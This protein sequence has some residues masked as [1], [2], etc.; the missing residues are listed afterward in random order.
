[1][2]VRLAGLGSHSSDRN[3]QPLRLR[4]LTT[5]RRLQVPKPGLSPAAISP[6]RVHSQTP[7]Y[8]R[9][10]GSA[11][12]LTKASFPVIPHVQVHIR[13]ITPLRVTVREWEWTGTKEVVVPSSQREGGRHKLKL[14]ERKGE[15]ESSEV[16][17]WQGSGVRGK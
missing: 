3:F 7:L 6:D 2:Q 11:F 16:S 12:R 10:T 8:R 4:T 9:R 13:S 1:M 17:P 5:H 15:E 14:R